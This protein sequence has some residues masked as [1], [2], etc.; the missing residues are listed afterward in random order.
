[1]PHAHLPSVHCTRASARRARKGRASYRAE[2]KQ[3][4][5]EAVRQS[6]DESKD[7]IR[8]MRETADKEMSAVQ[9]ILKSH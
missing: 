3:R 1:M 7:R 2:W 9:R 8:Q 5:R 4:L 6:A